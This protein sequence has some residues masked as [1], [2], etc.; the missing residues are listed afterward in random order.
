MLVLN[1]SKTAVRYHK[2]SIMDMNIHASMDIANIS[3]NFD[4]INQTEIAII[5]GNARNIIKLIITLKFKNNIKKNSLKVFLKFS[6][7]NLD[8]SHID[9]NTFLFSKMIKYF[10][11]TNIIFI[12]TE[13]INI[14]INNILIYF[15]YSSHK[16][17]KINK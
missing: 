7:T 9:W 13:N 2:N 14:T 11:Y 4:V 16:N 17:L 1:T 8:D 5:I 6:I 15:I 12:I 10:E 3:M